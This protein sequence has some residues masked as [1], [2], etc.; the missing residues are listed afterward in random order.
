MLGSSSPQKVSV[1]TLFGDPEKATQCGFRLATGKGIKQAT[2]T[3]FCRKL[4]QN[5]AESAVFAQCHSEP[6]VKNLKTLRFAQGDKVECS[7]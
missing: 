5:C 6:K 1:G 3:T 4:R 2:S 7:E